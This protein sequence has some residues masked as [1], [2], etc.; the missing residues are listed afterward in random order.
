MQ[1][2]KFLGGCVRKEGKMVKKQENESQSNQTL[3]NFRWFFLIVLIILI[4]SAF[5]PTTIDFLFIIGEKWDIFISSSFSK[6][7]ILDYYGIILAFLG[8]MFLG[9]ITLWQN[10]QIE[11]L[12]DKAQEKLNK[13]V[14]KLADANQIIAGE[15][16]ELNWKER[17]RESNYFWHKN[18]ILFWSLLKLII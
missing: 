5:G 9:G 11:K 13:A 8:T 10:H 2:S 1:K 16:Q 7:E 18:I 15:N 12:N 3:F 14:E 6:A 4:L 17:I